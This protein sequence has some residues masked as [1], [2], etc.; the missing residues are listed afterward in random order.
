MVKP[1]NLLTQSIICTLSFTFSVPSAPT[2]VQVETVAGQ[3]NQLLVM[4]QPPDTPNG[5]IMDYT[6]YCF[7]SENEPKQDA[8]GD[9]GAG[10]EGSMASNSIPFQNST[11]DVTVLGTE[12]STV[13][14]SLDPYTRYSCVVIAYTSIGEGRPSSTASG[15]TD[16]SSKSHLWL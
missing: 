5:L 8:S 14:G 3:P 10:A 6:T 13:V 12:T 1:I 16:E 4:W 2:S 9:N 11:S 7:E 15:V